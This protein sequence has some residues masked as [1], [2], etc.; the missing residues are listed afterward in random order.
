M[1]PE[2]ATPVYLLAILMAT[3]LMGTILMGTIH[4]SLLLDT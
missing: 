2:R 3:I 4:T 1:L